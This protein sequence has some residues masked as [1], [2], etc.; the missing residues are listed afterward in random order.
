MLQQQ[1][2]L[3]SQKGKRILLIDDE[4]DTCMVY[5]IVLEDADFEY[6]S[7]T[8]PVKALKEFRPIYY[9]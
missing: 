1:D 7:Y 8:D 9:Y 6:V 4:P 5:Q 2:K 3:L